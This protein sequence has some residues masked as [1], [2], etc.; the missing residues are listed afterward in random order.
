MEVYMQCKKCNSIFQCRTTIDGKKVNLQNRKYCLV[1]SPFKQ[2]NTK[3]LDKL[4]VEK[5]CLSC[6]KSMQ[7][8]L[9]RKGKLCWSCT[10]KKNREEKLEKVKLL[11][12]DTCWFCNYSR[13]WNALEFHHVDP[14]QKLFGLSI[15]EMQYAWD[16]IELELRKC[17]L[18]CACCH[19]EI[20]CGLISQ[21]D[22][23][24]IW[25]EKWDHTLKVKDSAHN[26]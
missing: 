16:R 23:Q 19:R 20:H 15:R 26:G 12:G 11:V 10:N 2:H 14:K 4:V 21:D 9:E 24:K 1:C 22:V 8:K 17:V 25:I 5:N 6:G 3:I 18:V 13:C 7:R